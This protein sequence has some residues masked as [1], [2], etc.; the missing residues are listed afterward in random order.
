MGLTR[1]A[2]RSNRALSTRRRDQPTGIDMISVIS[3]HLD[4]ALAELARILRPGGRAVVY[5]TDFDSLVWHATD[6]ER[7]KSIYEAFND[8]CPR[9]HLGSQLAPH[10]RNAGLTA[11]QV[12]SNSILNTRLDEKT[13]AYH[14]VEGIKTYVVNRGKITPEVATAWLMTYRK[15]TRTGTR[16][17]T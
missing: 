9:P 15:L 5:D 1:G 12:E 6:Q 8:Y 17:A 13:F 3:L 2:T 7:L 16:S 11:E 10:V 4:T 14:L